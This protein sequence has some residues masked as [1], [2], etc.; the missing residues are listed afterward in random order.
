MALLP[1]PKRPVV[2]QIGRCSD[3]VGRNV[4]DLEPLFHL[5]LDELGSALV[6]LVGVLIEDSG[7]VLFSTLAT[8]DHQQDQAVEL[9]VCV[10]GVVHVCGR[11]RSR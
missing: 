4:L 9:R 3:V 7:M 6:P 8:F 1:L 10:V 11:L 2:V 5:A